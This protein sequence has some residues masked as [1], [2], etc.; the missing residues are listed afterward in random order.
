[1]NAGGE[2]EADGAERGRD[3]LGKAAL[4]RPAV[5][6]D[7]ADALVQGV[8]AIRSGSPV[9]VHAQF[10]AVDRTCGNQ[11]PKSEFCPPVLT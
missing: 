10:F 5:H 2:K 7:G 3:A 8:R 4:Q 6:E 9:H 11:R 1:M